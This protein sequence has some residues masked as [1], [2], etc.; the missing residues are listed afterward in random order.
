MVLFL[1]S[2]RRRKGAFTLQ[3][4]LLGR[5]ELQACNYLPRVSDSTSITTAPSIGPLIGGALAHSFGWRS[6]FWFLCIVSATC[7]TL[8]LLTL[9]ETARGVVGNGNLEPPRFSR[10]PHTTCIRH[11]ASLELMHGPRPK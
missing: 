11:R 1:I 7:L 4:C 5:Y 9:P 3:L 8:M 10:L 2:L 6:I